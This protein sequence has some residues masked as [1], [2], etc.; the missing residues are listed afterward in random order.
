MSKRKPKP[1]QPT[2]PALTIHIAGGF[3]SRTFYQA[4]QEKRPEVDEWQ[5]LGYLTDLFE[6]GEI[7]CINPGQVDSPPKYQMNGPVIIEI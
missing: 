6:K 3:V 2:R 4:I 1:K 5:A 7:E